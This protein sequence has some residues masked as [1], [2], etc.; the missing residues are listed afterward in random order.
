MLPPSQMVSGCRSEAK[1]L[2]ANATNTPSYHATAVET[3]EH[4]ARCVI[5]VDLN[6]VRAGVVTHPAAGETAG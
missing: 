3:G 2:A 5:Y 1:P 6:L 4:L